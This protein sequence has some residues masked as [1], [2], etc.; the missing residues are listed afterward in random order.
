MSKKFKFEDDMMFAPP[1]FSDEVEKLGGKVY[2]LNGDFKVHNE[3]MKKIGNDEQR[4]LGWEQAVYELACDKDGNPIYKGNL[5]KAEFHRGCA[6]A[7]A[8]TY[9]A[10]ILGISEGDEKQTTDFEKEIEEG[11]KNSNEPEQDTKP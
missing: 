1:V 7:K 11:A 10:L 4:Q 8:R 6:H 5:S 2:W 9:G 3:I